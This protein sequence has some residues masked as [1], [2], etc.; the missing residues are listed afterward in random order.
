MGW[1]SLRMHFVSSPNGLVYVSLL[2]FLALDFLSANM[3]NNFD[4]AIL[5]GHQTIWV[6]ISMLCIDFGTLPRVMLRGCISFGFVYHGYDFGG[7]NLFADFV[8]LISK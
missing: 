4:Y 7:F 2:F 8:I 6:S 3:A 5:Q 1:I